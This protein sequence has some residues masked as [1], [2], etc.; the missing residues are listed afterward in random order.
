MGRALD[1]K[2]KDLDA[3][4]SSASNKAVCDL[5]TFPSLAFFT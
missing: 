4:N 3:N 5:A 2:S 1:F